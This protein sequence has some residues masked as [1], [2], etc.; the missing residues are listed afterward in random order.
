M[1][2]RTISYFIAIIVKVCLFRYI[3]LITLQTGNEKI[4]YPGMVN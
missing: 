1:I 2:L 3:F 4:P